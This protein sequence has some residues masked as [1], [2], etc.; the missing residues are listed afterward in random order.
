MARLYPSEQKIPKGKVEFS[1]RLDDVLEILFTPHKTAINKAYRT[2]DYK[3]R[4]LEISLE[5]RTIV[6]YPI[7]VW[8]ND[9]MIPRYSTLSRITL[10]YP[11]LDELPMSIVELDDL[12]EM[13]FPSMLIQ[14]YNFGFGFRK[15]YQ[16]ISL[17]FER[18]GV[19][20]LHILDDVSKFKSEPGTGAVART[21]LLRLGR[22]L[23]AIVR[24]A[25]HVSQEV[26]SEV[27]K[28]SVRLMLDNVSIDANSRLSS[29]QIVKLDLIA[30]QGAIKLLSPLEQNGAI[31][32]VENNSARIYKDQPQ[33]LIK[34]RNNID[35]VTLEDL[36]EQF[37]DMLTKP[38]QES[39]W[40]AILKKNPFILSMAFGI[41][42]I[43]IQDQAYVGGQKLSGE[44]NKIADFLVKNSITSNAAI[45]EI[46]KPT[47]KLLSSSPY[48]Q[49]IFGPS[50]DLAGGIT[51]VLDQIYK[52]QKNVLFIKDESRI[53]ELET[54]S[55]SGILIIGRI[56]TSFSEKKSFELI[57]GNSKSVGIL[58][59]DELL[60]KLK[61]LHQFLKD[62]QI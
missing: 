8:G 38:L 54:F 23:D 51:Q 56:P 21:E 31:S 35:L 58:T 9:P 39:H 34:L 37:E 44:G 60:G 52:F 14:D 26:R 57:R 33:R 15:D 2:S 32:L 20:H 61:T 5:H 55:V 59:F 1:L 17:A 7:K 3:K 49:E 45:V 46:K 6:I 50:T 42:I 27:A 22:K 18:F 53:T 36:I 11:W 29:D 13:A 4:I 47:S 16:S 43:S 40:Q 10:S 41:S 19:E 12:I 24:K 30:Q 25:R 48:R 62:S 28:K